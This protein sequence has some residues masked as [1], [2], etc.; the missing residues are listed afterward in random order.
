MKRSGV[1]SKYL[2]NQTA[3]NCEMYKKQK[4]KTVVN[5][6][7][8]KERDIT[9]ILVNLNDNGR[10]WKTVKPFLSNEGCYISKIHVARKYKII[11]DGLILAETFNKFFEKL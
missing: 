10:F 3:H 4:K 5:Y 2:K 7:K 9:M 8:E 6:I 11:S 1:K